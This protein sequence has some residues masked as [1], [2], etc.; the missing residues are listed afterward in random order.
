M[1]TINVAGLRQNLSEYLHCVEKGEE[2][3]VTSHHRPVARLVPAAGTAAPG[4][5]PSRA[6]LSAVRALKGIKLNE[7]IP[8]ESYLSEDRRRR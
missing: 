8:A 2:V 5:R 7:G 4:I 1:K 6:P 3:Q